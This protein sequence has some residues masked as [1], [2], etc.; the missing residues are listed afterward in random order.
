M[1][2]QHPT[3][4][5]DLKSEQSSWVEAQEWNSFDVIQ[6]PA[7]VHP[8][9]LILRHPHMLWAQDKIQRSPQINRR[10]FFNIPDESRSGKSSSQQSSRFPGVQGRCPRRTPPH[11]HH[12]GQ[13][14]GH[15][16]H[17][18]PW[19]QGPFPLNRFQGQMRISE[20]SGVHPKLQM[21]GLATKVM[22]QIASLSDEPGQLV[23][24]TGWEQASETCLPVIFWCVTIYP[25][26]VPEHSGAQETSARDDRGLKLRTSLH[27]PEGGHTDTLSPPIV[28]SLPVVHESRR[29]ENTAL[30]PAMK[31]T[32][33]R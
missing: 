24:S 33:Q 9:I 4:K 22:T 5:R 12:H 30:K 3:E 32:P 28:V 18:G 7:S 19:F 26:I 25:F 8:S 11:T 17:N 13:A 6:T 23:C 21:W 14:E 20:T 31:T 2:W 1:C 27:H 15:L 10:S 29:E 16:L